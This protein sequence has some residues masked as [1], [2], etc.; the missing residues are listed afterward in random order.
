M[1]LYGVIGTNNPAA[2]LAE[3]D[4]VRKLAVPMSPG[5]GTISRGTVCYRTSAGLYA[6]ATAANVDGNSQVVVLDEAVDTNADPNIAQVAAAYREAT[7]IRRKVMLAAGAAVTTAVELMLRK[8]GIYLCADGSADDM[9]NVAYI[10]TYKANGGTGDDVAETVNA[11]TATAK[12]GT[13]FTAPDGEAFSEWNTE[14]DGSG[15]GF[16]AGAS[17]A[18]VGNLTL[19]AIWA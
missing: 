3:V 13:T 7:L 2:L 19:Y 14:S 16:V 17:I 8:Q 9:N 6:P 4:G 5:N 12:V 11:L 1:N 15:D 18:L 10:I